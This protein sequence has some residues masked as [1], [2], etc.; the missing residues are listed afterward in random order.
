MSSYAANASNIASA[1]SRSLY[2]SKASS[3]SSYATTMST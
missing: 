1:T 2:A 3:M